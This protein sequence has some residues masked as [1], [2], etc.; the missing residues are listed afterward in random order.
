MN[1]ATK[2]DAA[3]DELGVPNEDYPSNVANAVRLLQRAR[4]EH[5]Q[6]IEAYREALRWCGGSADFGLG[7]KARDGWLH[8]VEPLI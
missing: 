6:E 8:V 1:K 3:L 2:I 4:T 5:E 7:G